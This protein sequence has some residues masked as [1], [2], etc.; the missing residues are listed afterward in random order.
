[1]GEALGDVVFDSL[2][3]SCPPVL[4]ADSDHLADSSRTVFASPGSMGERKPGRWGTEGAERAGSEHSRELAKDAC[5]LQKGRSG[6]SRR[7]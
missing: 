6:G 2:S 3:A 1:M 7:G 5:G 4:H